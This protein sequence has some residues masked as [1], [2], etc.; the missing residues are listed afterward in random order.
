MDMYCLDHDVLICDFC[1][2]YGRHH[3]HAVGLHAEAE[4]T[5]RPR[6]R[7]QLSYMRERLNTFNKA[8]EDVQG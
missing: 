1:E 4:R 6:L 2:R 7:Q 3:G 5:I 8:I